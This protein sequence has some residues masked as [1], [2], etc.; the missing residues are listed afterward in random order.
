MG[1]VERTI[2]KDIDGGDVSPA[3]LAFVEAHV[4]VALGQQMDSRPTN[5][6]LQCNT[7]GWWESG[8][9]RLRT[10]G[11]E[12][13]PWPFKVVRK[14]L[15]RSLLVRGPNH[16]LTPQERRYAGIPEDSVEDTKGRMHWRDWPGLR[17][18]LEHGKQGEYHRPD[19]SASISEHYVRRWVLDSGETIPVTTTVNQEGVTSI[20]PF[21]RSWGV[22]EADVLQNYQVSTLTKLNDKDRDLSDVVPDALPEQPGR[23][24]PHQPRFT[25]LRDPV[26]DGEG[27]ISQPAATFP[28]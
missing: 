19:A 22:L 20:E 12:F 7:D 9:N 25:Y 27:L 16:V 24:F 17:W 10:Y 1:G 28:I 4:R 15:T 23:G 13:V 14:A 21:Q 6:L 5:K 26:E 8:A 3:V 2:A 11:P 18:Q